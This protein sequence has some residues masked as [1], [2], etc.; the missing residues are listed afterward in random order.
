MF[1]SVLSKEQTHAFIECKCLDDTKNLRQI[2]C[3]LSSSLCWEESIYIIAYFAAIVIERKKKDGKDV[4]RIIQELYS[5]PEHMFLQLLPLDADF[6][7]FMLKHVNPETDTV[8]CTLIE[9]YQRLIEYD[10]SRTLR[11]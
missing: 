9:M 11:M 4:K 1:A 10:Y 6:I 3:E 2:E 5:M 7:D 8:E